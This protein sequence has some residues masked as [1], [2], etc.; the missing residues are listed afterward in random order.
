M[1]CTGTKE[2][3]HG[4]P[5]VKPLTWVLR[6]LTVVM[7]GALQK[8]SESQTDKMTAPLLNESQL[9]Q[10]RAAESKPFMRKTMSR[11]C[12]ERELK[13]GKDTFLLC[14]V[15][16]CIYCVSSIFYSTFLRKNLTTSPHQ[17]LCMCTLYLSRVPGVV[18]RNQRFLQKAE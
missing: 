8:D 7:E 1:G 5:S 11:V 3:T 13:T 16:V 15:Y 18:Q 4:L 14:T 9:F 2:K 17:H 12:L 10:W 6:L